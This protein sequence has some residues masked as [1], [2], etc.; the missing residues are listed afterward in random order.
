MYLAANA[1][2]G[3]QGESAKG[4]VV[5]QM[6]RIDQG[7]VAQ[8][9]EEC[10]AEVLDRGKYPLQQLANYLEHQQQH[11]DYAAAQAQGLRI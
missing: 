10:P 11:L 4:W 7:K 6:G 1:L 9:I 5:R 2:L 8:G 3:D